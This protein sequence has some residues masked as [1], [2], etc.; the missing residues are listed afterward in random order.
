[1]PAPAQWWIDPGE[2]HSGYIADRTQDEHYPGLCLQQGFQLKP[3]RIYA[4]RPVRQS[5]V[6]ARELCSTFGT[7]FITGAD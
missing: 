3:T 1:M 7:L 2:S 6:P 4:Q 5:K